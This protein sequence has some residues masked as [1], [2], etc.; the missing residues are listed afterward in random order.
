M[1]DSTIE[2][3]SNRV[4]VSRATDILDMEPQTRR[5]EEITDADVADALRAVIARGSESDK[6]LGDVSLP[7]LSFD[8][9]VLEGANTYPLDLT[10]ATIDSLCLERA[11]V[12]VPL[13]LDDAEIGELDLDYARLGRDLSAREA[14]VESLAGYETVFDGNAEFCG[15]TITG[16]AAFREATFDDDVSFDEVTFEGEVIFDAAELYGDSNR[17]DDNTS[18]RNAHFR[19]PVSFRQT[20]G[21]FTSFEGSVFEEEA[22]FSEAT[23]DGD[24]DFADATFHSTATFEESEFREDTTFANAAFEGEAVFEGATFEGGAHVIEDDLTFEGAVF[25]ATVT[26]EVATFRE[27]NFARAE[28]RGEATFEQCEWDRDAA[29]CAATFEAM[30]DFDEARFQADADFTDTHFEGECD[31][32]GAEFHGGDNHLDVAATFNGVSFD[33]DADFDNALFGT[34]EFVDVVFAGLADFQGAVFE[35]EF[36]LDVTQRT[37]DAYVNCTEAAL[38]TGTIV[39]PDGGWVR[40]DFT[41]ASLGSVSLSSETKSDRKELLDYFRFCETEFNEFDGHE[42][43]FSEHTDYLDRNNWELHVFDDTWADYEPTVKLRPETIERTYLKAKIA[44]SSV[45]NQQAAGEFRVKRQQ[46]ARKKYWGIA[47]NGAED[48][49]TRARNG[50]R[51]IENLFLGI[52]CGYGLRLFRIIGVFLIFPVFPALLYTFGGSAFATSGGPINDRT[53]ASLSAVVTPEGAQVLF[54]N[55]AFS[56]ITF[57]TVGYGNVGPTGW[58]AK[59]LAATEVYIGVILGGLL[60]YALIKRSEV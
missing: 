26:F 57:L 44:A 22:V 58:A 53:L 32:R 48:A 14:T 38:K 12:R 2:E 34:A 23:F 21:E 17:L 56:Y 33:A 51:A 28:F 1:S 18:F 31:F 30:A 45:G 16:Q 3:G 41:R 9:E 60:L 20:V 24:V 25:E 59:I 6:Q 5:E 50:L 27:A 40:Y 7:A 54:E 52:S 42:F 11:D 35:G 13:V 15:A 43:D 39:Q 4:A 55:V 49:A 36:T 37:N 8:Y 47:R 29:F 19:G 46:F 10:G